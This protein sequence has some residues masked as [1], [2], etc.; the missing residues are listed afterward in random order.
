LDPAASPETESLLI[1]WTSG[2]RETAMNMV[3]LYGLNALYHG[4][5]DEVT[6]LVWGASQHLLAEDTEV[7]EKVAEL[8]DAGVRVVAC[9]RCA[10]NLG[11]A[12]RLGELQCE[13]FPTGTLLSDWLKSGKPLLTV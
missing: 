8:A 9:Q 4:W 13:V 12:D 3:L 11:V 6:L 10:E 5:F 2:D 7:Q 1:L